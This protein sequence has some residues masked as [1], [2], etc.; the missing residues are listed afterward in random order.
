MKEDKYRQS[1]NPHPAII[2]DFPPLTMAPEKGIIL[3]FVLNRKNDADLHG[4]AV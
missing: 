3:I 1:F 4:K 2:N